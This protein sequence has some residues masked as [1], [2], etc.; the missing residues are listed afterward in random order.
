MIVI[1]IFI[2]ILYITHIDELKDIIRSFYCFNY[3]L[4]LFKKEKSFF[5]SKLPIF[6]STKT[7][8]TKFNTNTLIQNNIIS[9]SSIEHYKDYF[10]SQ[11]IQIKPNM[12]KLFED[13]GYDIN[14][15]N[16]IISIK[17][18]LIRWFFYINIKTRLLKQ[19][20]RA[21][22]EGFIKD[23]E[24]LGILCDFVNDNFYL[25]SLSDSLCI[26]EV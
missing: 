15:H 9:L 10:M 18:E 25:E 17:P 2:L 23:K 19:S 20:M 6:K 8:K 24:S 21:I 3:L 1:I 11:L 16:N 14:K 22:E 26:E 7:H 13:I 5:T 12:V 4:S